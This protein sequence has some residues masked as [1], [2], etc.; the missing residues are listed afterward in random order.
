MN[1]ITARAKPGKPAIAI[2][3][4]PIANSGTSATALAVAYAGAL[5]G[6]RVLLVDAASANA[7]LSTVFAAEFADDAVVMLDNKD[8]LARITTRDARS[9]LAFL[10]IALADLRML[11][12]Q[13]A[14]P[15]RDR[16]DRARRGL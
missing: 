1:R 12:E 2:F 14:P 13:S 11:E 15:A 6:D 16:A 10:P 3:L 9:G 4:A 5:A 7:E 8:H